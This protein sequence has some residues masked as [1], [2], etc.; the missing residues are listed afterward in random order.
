[1]AVA[2]ADEVDAATRGKG[3]LDRLV[4]PDRTEHT[5]LALVESGKTEEAL[6]SYDKAIQLKP[7][8]A[9]ALYNRG[10]V[11][12]DLGQFGEALESYNE[13]IRL[14]PDYSEAYYG[15]SCLDE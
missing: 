2:F 7:D 13:A 4:T 3:P 9:N 12:R 14:I 11:Q 5:V 6:A 15:R 8:Y 1:M 10:N